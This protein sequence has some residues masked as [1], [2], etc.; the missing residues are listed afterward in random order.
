ME[1]KYRNHIS[2]RFLREARTFINELIEGTNNYRQLN[3]LSEQFPHDYHDRF[4]VEL[5]QNANDAST[6]GEVRIILDEINASVPRL[7]VA[8]QGKSF[9]LK[10]FEALCSLGLSDK[11]P[12]EAI[13][14]KG[15]GFRSVLQICRD[16]R[17]YS[18]ADMLFQEN[19]ESFNGFC[20]T[21]TPSSRAV[22]IE[23]IDEIQHK[24]IV[25]NGTSE[26]VKKHFGVEVPLLS[27]LSRIERL[28]SRIAIGDCTVTEEARYLSPYSFP[29]PLIDY[30]A[31]INI[32]LREKF[33]TVVE[34]ILNKPEDVS[35][36]KRAISNIVPEYLLF[37][38][39]LTKL[40]VE[41]KTHSNEK[42]L[43]ISLEKKPILEN[44][45]FYPPPPLTGLQ[46]V[47]KQDSI[48]EG[49]EG[50][51]ENKTVS[52]EQENPNSRIWWM[53][54]GDVSG[55]DLKLALQA[56]PEK[57][58]EIS[59]V[60]VN[61]ALE[62]TIQE[63]KPGLFS[64]YLPTEQE[65]GSALS[66]NG[67]FYGNLSRTNIDFSQKY[68]HILLSK[69]VEL[70]IEMLSYISKTGSLRD[71]VA[72]LDILDCKDP[73]SILIQ[74]FDKKLEES[75]S[76]LSQIKVI[77]LESSN[78]GTKH[79]HKLGPI[80]SVRILPEPNQP[81]KLLTPS[82]LSKVGG[83]FPARFITENRLAALS[84]LA[85]RAG[86][87]L[88]LSN[89]EI[90]DLIEKLALSLPKT[91]RT[92]SEWNLF[93]REISELNEALHFQDALRT[94][95]FLLTEDQRLIA[96]DGDGPKIFAFPVRSGTP[97]ENMLEREQ[98]DSNKPRVVIPT[99]IKSLVA[100]LHSGI[101]LTEDSLSHPFN[102][103]G[104]FLRQGNPPLVRD[105]ETRV[106]V[107]EVIIPLV[108]KASKRNSSLSMQTL[109]QSL[110]WAY[111]LYSSVPAD[112]TFAGVQWN[113]L[114][115]P[116]ISGWKL[117]TESYFSAE[118][119]GTL[120]YILVKAFPV[121]HNALNR[122]M[123]APNNF[124]KLVVGKSS[125]FNNDDLG[126]WVTF[127]RNQCGVLETPRIQQ[128][129][130]QKTRS[131]QEQIHLRMS[132]YGN[133]YFTS[134]LGNYFNL[135]NSI[136]VSYIAYL[137]DK[138]A[139]PIK[140]FEYYYLE[141]QATLDGLTDVNKNTATSYVQ[142]VARE[143][144]EMQNA[145]VTI[146]MRRGAGLTASWSKADST[147][148]FTLKHL[149][150]LPYVSGDDTAV[151]GLLDPDHIWFIPSDILD[152]P[153]SRMRY[154]FVN[155]LPQDVAFQMNNDFRQ[156]L[157]IRAEK[158][159]SAEDGLILL[160]DLATSWKNDLPPER[161][162]F[163]L[164]LWRDTLVETARLWK[165]L[166]ESEQAALL[167]KSQERGLNG[168]IMTPAGRR[169]PEWRNLNSKDGKALL[170]YL[171]DEIELRSSMGEWVDIAEMR[172]EQISNQ[173]ALLKK[174]FGQNVACISDLE[175]VPESSKE[176]DLHQLMDSTP[177]LI[178]R[179]PWMEAFVLTIYGLGRTQEMNI[180]GDEF[181]RVSRNFRRLKYLEIPGL[182]LRIK[183][184]E[185]AKPPLSPT[186]YYWDKYNVLL[187]NPETGSHCEDLV[188]GLRSFFGVQ[189]I[190]SQL[191]LALL[192]L[193]H[194]LDD[195]D[196]PEYELQV[197]SL[198]SLHISAEQF[199]RIR[200]IVSLGDDEWILTRLVPTICAINK[201]NDK[202]K[203]E[204]VKKRFLDLSAD[205]GIE[206]ALEGMG[207]SDIHLENTAKLYEL[208]ASATSDEDM[209]YKLWSNYQLP[210][211]EW[212][213][214]IRC[215]GSPYRICQ[216]NGIEDEFNVIIQELK[217]VVIAIARKVL[218]INGAIDKYISIKHSYDEIIP[219]DFW[220]EQ[221]WQLPIGAVVK[222]VRRWFGS[223]F[224]DTE[225]ELLNVLF[226]SIENVQQIR[227]IAIE[228]ELDLDHNDDFIEHQ[229][230][231]QVENL[232]E[233]CLIRILAAWIASGHEKS[234][235]PTAVSDA[236]ATNDLFS[237]DNTKSICQ[238]E[239]ISENISMHILI[240]YF[241]LKG[242]FEKLGIE[243]KPW[244][245]LI[246]LAKNYPVTNEQLA[247]ATERLNKVNE[248]NQ[249]MAR[250]R[251]I[252]GEDYEIPNGELF[253]GLKDIIDVKLGKN[254]LTKINLSHDPWLGEAPKPVL[255]GGRGRSH[256]SGGGIS[257]KD[258]DLI[259]AVGEY[260]IYKALC[261]QIGVAA[262]GQSWKSRNRRHFLADNTGD[263]SLGYDFEFPKEGILWEIEVK[264]SSGGPQFVDLTETEVE[265]A[266]EAAKHRIR[267]YYVIYL[268]NYVLSSPEPYL[269]G[270][271]FG[272][273]DRTRFRIEEGGARVYFKLL[274][275]PSSV[276]VKQQLPI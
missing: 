90:I 55:K 204:C 144:S 218:K 202:T 252:L 246:S 59:E 23:L 167:V 229:N 206:K 128:T 14:N 33:V 207:E 214:S 46:I 249:H 101:S 209:A 115:V 170:T 137:K 169:F 109:A 56:L 123:V 256:G 238:F 148:A 263:D 272:T 188:S 27:E 53:H 275:N 150:W 180:T 155:H 73:T 86:S 139:P 239:P 78:V 130:F 237:L 164:D 54:A 107:N 198:Q 17:I 172:G 255:P 127:L 41:H 265:V 62:R 82:R 65:T 174:L 240:E 36:A 29:L 118:W 201:I 247:L 4:L 83:C 70:M 242:V 106:L 129:I 151:K 10:N 181:R 162:Q 165:D 192:K 268:V 47:R 133:T 210:L 236:R 241:T 88:N 184:I 15:L 225:T 97:V 134:E 156:F 190:E 20:F 226:A 136:W 58:H 234:S 264:S 269:L 203:A 2:D 182:Q 140:S 253:E 183:G 208:A 43:S 38:P 19:C 173:V 22:V 176:L 35:A 245:S 124:A 154:S 71:G 258:R 25:A 232:I 189:D 76:S 44:H 217:P 105:Y 147:L 42:N 81:R 100:F 186:C 145:F 64:I 51:I 108:S 230:R 159:S 152:S 9:T 104:R 223:Q 235:V 91:S 87:N 211:F 266:R 67:P 102:S 112:T 197:Q 28:R 228:L 194:T 94:C 119:T 113:R 231:M 18:K 12:K 273:T 116:T 227:S 257:Q 271:P 187:L 138:L 21:L 248:Y 213:N 32:F 39:K 1:E 5:I 131:D 222:V 72:L 212:N 166:T 179:F 143:F 37:T 135:P 276:G 77:Y 3:S 40:T 63:P 195:I 117:A 68:N 6:G 220:K 205:L 122:L 270:N 171:P 26:V 224:P 66:V 114:Y 175:F 125:I 30:D 8:N 196:S 80:S 89:T 79:S 45:I 93:Y 233:P 146:A 161:H 92:L 132:G 16:P 75:G 74:L 259:G 178:S 191:H 221:F 177:S 199:D 243:K 163:F 98:S 215:L 267:K 95:R 274:K 126:R 7:F 31:S 111:Q 168:L 120:G 52:S 61:I 103:V 110:S 34:L 69:A 254:I 200:R 149:P 85:K 261:S 141:R 251:N 244:N 185:T 193:G 262:A 13:G 216:N 121:G 24:D 11:D 260:I 60:T 142:L 84:R 153:L 48:S 157:G 160:A 50:D 57:W 219:E 158:I 49:N 96:S 250:T 99:R